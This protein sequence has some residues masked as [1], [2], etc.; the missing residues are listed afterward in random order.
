[1]SQQQSKPYP[2]Y[3]PSGVEWLG[4]V[5]EHWTVQRIKHSM[6]NCKNGIWGNEAQGNDDD[7]PCVRVADFNRQKLN[8]TLDNPTI[9]NISKKDRSDRTLQPGNLLIEKSGGGELQPVGCVVLYDDPNPAVCS[10][11]IARIQIAEDMYPSFW[12]YVHAAAYSIRLTTGSINQTSGIQNL[13]Q[14][15]YFDERAAYPPFEE[16]K[17]IANF[18]DRETAKIDELMAEQGRLIDLLKEKRQ[19][20]I[21][22]A[23]TKGLNPDALMKDSGIEWLGEVPSHWE[24]S[25]IKFVASHIVDCLHSTPNYDGEVEFPAIR[26]ADIIPGRLLLD[27]ARLVSKEVYEERVQRLIPIEGDILYSREGE[28]FGMAAL[29][30]QGVEL[31]L[32]Q[33][34]MMFRI[35]NTEISSYFMWVLNSATVYQQVLERMAGA[36]SPHVNIADIINFYIPYPPVEEQQLISDYIQN[37]INNF[38]HL[39]AQA[40]RASELLQERRTALISAAVTGK[41]DVRSTVREAALV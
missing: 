19:A 2:S 27:N 4:D 5:P 37:Q 10:N 28:R 39:I 29:V 40:E 15:R 17:W 36:T 16:Q 12:R 23:V 22:H 31:C 6:L 18:L 24:V 1:M 14:T 3:K 26:T 20:V 7:I 35:K 25:R 41:I 11:F 34:M 38:D 32:G 8:V 30:P 33:R 13:D 9:R 21:S